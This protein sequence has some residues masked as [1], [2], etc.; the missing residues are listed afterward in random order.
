MWTERLSAEHRTDGTASRLQRMS[1]I[2]SIE[3]ILVSNV[4]VRHR[5]VLTLVK[6]ALP[7]ERDVRDARA[8]KERRAVRGDDL[9][10][11]GL[12]DGVLHIRD[13]VPAGVEHACGSAIRAVARCRLGKESGRA[14]RR[15]ETPWLGSKA[16]LPSSRGSK[17]R[18]P[19]ACE[20]WRRPRETLCSS[21]ASCR[22]ENGRPRRPASYGSPPVPGSRTSK[23]GAPSSQ[24]TPWHKYQAGRSPRPHRSSRRIRN[25]PGRRATVT[26]A[27]LSDMSANV[28]CTSTT[29]R[30]C[31]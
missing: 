25:S 10:V 6:P 24:S 4:V 11:P 16:R 27:Q 12:D 17:A 2:K 9:V 14:C 31:A 5:E 13:G 7:L 30:G 22:P 15:Q 3:H 26:G 1:R 20:P 28:P 19:Q 23:A 8:R 21:G 18:G 29:G